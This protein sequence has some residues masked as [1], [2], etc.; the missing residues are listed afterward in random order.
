MG[1]CEARNPP[2]FADRHTPNRGIGNRLRTARIGQNSF[3]LLCRSA[4]SRCLSDESL[5]ANTPGRVRAGQ[6]AQKMARTLAIPRNSLR[7]ESVLKGRGDASPFVDSSLLLLEI[8]TA[9]SFVSSVVLRLSAFHGQGRL[10]IGRGGDRRGPRCDSTS[11]G[12]ITWR[13]DLF[14]AFEAS[15]TQK[16]VSAPLRAEARRGC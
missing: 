14:G 5:G 6:L 8:R 4:I 1:Y 15:Q 3:D 13:D 10:K 11:R 7:H 12:L 16:K 2:G 9:S